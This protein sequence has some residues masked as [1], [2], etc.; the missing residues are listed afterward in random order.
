MG[1]GDGIAFEEVKHA[2]LSRVIATKETSNVLG[3]FTNHWKRRINVAARRPMIHQPHMRFISNYVTKYMIIMK[4][5]MRIRMLR[6]HMG[7]C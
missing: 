2:W 4:C 1:R 3:H 7:E 5:L 6:Y